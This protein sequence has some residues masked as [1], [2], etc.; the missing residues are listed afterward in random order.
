VTDQSHHAKLWPLY[1]FTA[2]IW[3]MPECLTLLRITWVTMHVLWV[4]DSNQNVTVIAACEFNWTR[5]SNTITISAST[6]T[7][8]R[9]YKK[10]LANWI[11]RIIMK[12][13]L[14]LMFDTKKRA[15]NTTGRNKRTLNLMHIVCKLLA[16][17]I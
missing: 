6:V 10:I 12:R 4:T 8:T 7:R 5:A 17:Y 3:F 2:V 13:N 16:P 1:Q 9:N 11:F 14:K 15:Q